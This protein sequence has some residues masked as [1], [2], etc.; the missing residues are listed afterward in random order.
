MFALVTGVQTGARP[1]S[2]LGRNGDL[3]AEL[4]KEARALL[5]LRTLAVHDVLEFG[6]ACHWS[7]VVS[8]GWK[9]A[10]ALGQSRVSHNNRGA[11]GADHPHPSVHIGRRSWRERG[12]TH[13]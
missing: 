11:A 3:A 9:L 7:D 12:W 8:W 2:H 6:L 13:A 5:V 4:G 10:R 1:I